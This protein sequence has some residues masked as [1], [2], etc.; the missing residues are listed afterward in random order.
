[1]KPQAGL[2]LLIAVPAM[3]SASA[4][5]A[6][7]EELLAGYA[8]QA[9]QDDPGFAGFS[10]A[11]GEAFHH[12]SFGRGKVDTPACTSCHADDP[13][14]AGKTPA[15]KII[16]PLALSASPSRY[17]DPAKVRKWFGRNCKEVLGRAC[18]AQEKG[19]WLSFMVSQ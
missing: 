18:T 3:A 14:A 11:R 15:G 17:A 9:K 13:R 6:P 2:L 7:R 10:T 19:D 5:A 12:R 1:M 16:D 8:A 4:L